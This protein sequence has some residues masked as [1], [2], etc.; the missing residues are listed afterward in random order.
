MK[1]YLLVALALFLTLTLTG[2]GT[3]EEQVKEPTTIPVSLQGIYK[4]GKYS[5]G[6]EKYTGVQYYFIYSVEN[7][8]VRRKICQSATKDC[9]F[10]DGKTGLYETKV[11][12][13]KDIKLQRDEENIDFNIYSNN[14]I[15]AKCYTSFGKISCTNTDGS[16]F[17]MSKQS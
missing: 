10:D 6:A 9:N 7:N 11:Y 1:K 13:V 17:T 14:E 15:Y 8:T 4:G 5:S 12:D 3:E 2:C 16:G